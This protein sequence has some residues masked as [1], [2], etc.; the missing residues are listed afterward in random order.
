MSQ[1]PSIGRIVHYTAAGRNHGDI[2]THAAIILG[3][4][5]SEDR[6]YLDIRPGIYPAKDSGLPDVRGPWYFE[7]SHL[8]IP[9]SDE[10][11]VGHWN[12]PPRT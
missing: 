5:Q 4:G 8:G 6:T 10:P 3:P 9:Y 12:W 1:A 7:D 2:I 11:K